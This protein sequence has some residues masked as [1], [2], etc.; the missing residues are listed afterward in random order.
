MIYGIKN[1]RMDSKSDSTPKVAPR[2]LK[3]L[4]IKVQHLKEQ[5]AK[6]KCPKAVRNEIVTYFHKQ[7]QEREI[8]RFEINSPRKVTFEALWEVAQAQQELTNAIVTAKI[9]EPYD[10]T[11]M[12]NPEP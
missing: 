10:P 6:K 8:D 12:H 4:K 7:L 9:K 2:I 3:N 1:N 11:G 5:R